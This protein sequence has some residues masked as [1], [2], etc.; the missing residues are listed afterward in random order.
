ML[1]D[2]G[3]GHWDT[4][5][6]SKANLRRVSVCECMCVHYIVGVHYMHICQYVWTNTRVVDQ[7]SPYFM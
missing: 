7:V 4:I 3:G 2:G 6:I 1:E 5:A